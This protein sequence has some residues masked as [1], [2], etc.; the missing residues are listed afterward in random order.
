MFSFFLF[1][2][3]CCTPSQ[4]QVIVEKGVC[5]YDASC[6]DGTPDSHS[7]VRA[8]LQAAMKTSQAHFE[9]TQSYAAPHTCLVR[10]EREGSDQT[11]RRSAR[12][13]AVAVITAVGTTTTGVAQQQQQQRQEG[14]ALLPRAPLGP[15]H[16]DRHHHVHPFHDQHPGEAL[17]PARRRRA[18]VGEGR[19]LRALWPRRRQV[20]RDDAAAA[21]AAAAAERRDCRRQR[22]RR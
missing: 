19:L 5:C 13:I 14:P 9:H 22:Q 15:L 18:V 1:P 6:Y 10:G 16:R 21:A 11:R 3:C 12:A 4:R 7:F 2:R 8:C 20:A 17:Q